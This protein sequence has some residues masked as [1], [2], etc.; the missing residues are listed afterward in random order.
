MKKILS[1]FLTIVTMVV[2]LTGCSK[3]IIN[4]KTES[5]NTISK[6]NTDTQKEE[7]TNKE[8]KTDDDKEE[9]L[10][11][12]EGKNI[13]KDEL[14]VTNDSE[15]TITKQKVVVI[16]PGH[17]KNGNKEME[18]I[19]PDSDQLK[20]KDPGGAQGITTNNPEYKVN[21]Q[22]ALKLK[23][24]LEL[25]NVKV[26]M[27]KTED[28]ENPGNVERAEIA[29]KINADLEIRIHCDS[30]E[31]QSAHGASMLVPDSIGY[32]ADISS[33]SRTYGETILESL[34]SN[35]GMYNRGIS[36]RSD[37]TGFNWS[38][39]PIVLVEMGFMSNNEED[40]LLSDD[41]YQNKLAQGLNDG[42]L[43]AL[44]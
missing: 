5:Q 7:K 31:N 34:V 29:N 37:L 33:I 21:L 18:A 25:N 4:D 22:V 8:E 1:I 40:I 11:A 43:K 2:L 32:A 35:A 6:S 12:K 3:F 13:N 28:S 26:V 9:M 17:G 15:E 23:E 41:A 20:I 24:L 10:N 42:I 16:D 36:V 19:S 38:K 44:E 14:T 39:V 27:T 30:A